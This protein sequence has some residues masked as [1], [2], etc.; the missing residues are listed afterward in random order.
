MFTEKDSYGG[1]KVRFEGVV[2]KKRG[3]GIYVQ[4][5][6]EDTQRYYGVYVYGGYASLAPK[7]LVP[8]YKLRISGTADNN[9]T[10]GFLVSG[11]SFSLINPADDDVQILEKDVD[12][13]PVLI[14]ADE[15]NGEDSPENVLVRMEGIKVKSVYTTTNETSS[16]KGAMTLTCETRDGKTV[17]VRTVVLTQ[18]G[19]L[20]TES[21]FRGKTMNV[22]GIVEIYEGSPQIKLFTLS[23]AEIID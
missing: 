12:I 18:Q 11:L 19:E 9:E 4:S 16:S 1:I 23:D 7:F 8:G 17:S 15:L 21:Y 14:T 6:D 22:T 13:S 10:F 2:T 5:F 20:V 3:E